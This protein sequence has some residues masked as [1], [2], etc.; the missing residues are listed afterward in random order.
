MGL[1]A[2][3]DLVLTSRTAG[4]DE[5]LRLGLVQRLAGHGQALA[6]AL[7]VAAE[8]AANDRDAVRELKR[9]FERFSG[10]RDRIDIEND[11]LHAL[12]EA[13]GDWSSL[14]GPSPPGHRSRR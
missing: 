4:A 2:A 6:V 10:L 14:R 1:G 7:G 8:I 11:A 5:A 13:D 9:Q 3:R 12:A